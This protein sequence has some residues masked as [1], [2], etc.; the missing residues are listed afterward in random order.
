MRCT[1]EVISVEEAA[2]LLRCDPRTVRRAI[3]AGQLPALQ[4]GRRYLLDRGVLA[5]RLRVLQEQ[6]REAV[7]TA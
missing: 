7:T 6:E 1:P 4:V 3:R 2:E 5:R